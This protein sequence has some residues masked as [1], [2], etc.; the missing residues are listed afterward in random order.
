MNHLVLPLENQ[1]QN[2]AWGSRQSLATLRGVKAPT[3]E[4]EAE[5]AQ[6][7]PMTPLLKH[8]DPSEAPATQP[9]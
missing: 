3:D 5:P 8:P 9:I 6:G 7:E 4:P 2:Y 1:I